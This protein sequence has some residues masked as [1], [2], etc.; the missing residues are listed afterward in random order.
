M[1]KTKS[2]QQVKYL[3]SKGSPLSDTQKRK[4]EDELHSGQVKVVQKK[5]DKKK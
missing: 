4:L 5:K 3:L 2:L 1:A